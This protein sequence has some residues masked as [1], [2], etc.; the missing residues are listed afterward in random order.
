MTNKPL[1][2]IVSEQ[3]IAAQALLKGLGS[4]ALQS[5]NPANIAKGHASKYLAKQKG[6]IVKRKERLK[7]R[8]MKPGQIH[9]DEAPTPTQKESMV[10]ESLWQLKL[11]GQPNL[12]GM[13]D[14]GKKGKPSVD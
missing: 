10:A 4:M 6:H 11:E 12:P 7:T 5:L 13:E 9:K 1:K 14:V 8:P 2:Q 3:G